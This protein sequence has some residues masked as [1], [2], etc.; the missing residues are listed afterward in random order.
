MVCHDVCPVSCDANTRCR[1]PLGLAKCHQ[2]IIA[3]NCPKENAVHYYIYIYYLHN[4][5]PTKIRL[6]SS[7]H[8]RPVIG[9]LSGRIQPG[10]SALSPPPFKRFTPVTQQ[11]HHLVSSSRSR[12]LSIVAKSPQSLHIISSQVYLS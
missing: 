9:V 5:L 7:T 2:Q 10:I 1:I 12:V 6:I 4:S 11:P 8:T 3:N